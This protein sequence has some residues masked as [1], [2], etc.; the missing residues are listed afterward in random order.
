MPSAVEAQNLNP[1]TAREVPG[2]VLFES[3]LLIH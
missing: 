2:E 1:W 3:E